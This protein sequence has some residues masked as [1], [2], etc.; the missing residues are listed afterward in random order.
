M[1][2]LTKREVVT[3]KRIAQNNYPTLAKIQTL[4]KKQEAIQ[5]EIDSYLS[6]LESLEY[7]AKL[8]TGGY[9]STDLIERVVKPAFDTEGNPK[10]DKE[11]NQLTV[12]KWQPVAGMLVDN[13]D[14]TMTIVAGE[15]Q[16][17]DATTESGELKESTMAE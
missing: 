3:L 15:T 17:G 6:S 2:T 4:R 8:L 13:E 9:C 16:E 10:L 1:K 12:T 14:G 5:A 11:G 7:G